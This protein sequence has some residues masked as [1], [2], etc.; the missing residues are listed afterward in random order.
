MADVERRITAR[1]QRPPIT[2][3]ALKTGATLLAPAIREQLA[4]YGYYSL[5]NVLTDEVARHITNEAQRQQASATRTVS[6]WFG[7]SREGKY[8]ASPMRFRSSRPG[9]YLNYLHRHP[10]TL[11]LVQAIAGQPMRPSQA[12]FMY[13]RDGSRVG[14]HTEVP[15]CQLVLLVSVIG[16]VPPLLVYPQMRGMTLEQLVAR[17]KATGGAPPGGVPLRI[18]RRGFAIL[19]GRKTPHRRPVVH[20]QGETIGLATLCYVA[21]TGGTLARGVQRLAGHG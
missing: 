21:G 15:G 14:L 17:A 18:P 19:R 4:R 11:R 9:R 12:S 7:I 5:T 2:A 13:Y 8:F 1:S 16:S 10:Q 20:T 6:T 3:P